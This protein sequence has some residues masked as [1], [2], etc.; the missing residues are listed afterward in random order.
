[1]ITSFQ[2]F[3]RPNFFLYKSNK[4]PK[5]QNIGPKISYVEHVNHKDLD[6][7]SRVCLLSFH[8]LASSNSIVLQDETYILESFQA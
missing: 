4:S 6:Q 8:H 7:V 1:M 5:S 3:F 2:N